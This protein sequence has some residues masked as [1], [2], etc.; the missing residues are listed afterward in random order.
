MLGASLSLR[1]V[2]TNSG[3]VLL[4]EAANRLWAYNDT[5]REICDRLREGAPEEVERVRSPINTV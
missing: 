4:D 3:L 1:R 5:A 2:A